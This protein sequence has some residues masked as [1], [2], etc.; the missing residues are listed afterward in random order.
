V[1]D[2]VR[3]RFAHAIRGHVDALCSVGGDRHPGSSRNRAAVVYAAQTM[4]SLGVE[5]EAIEFEVPE[6]SYGRAS[7]AVGG[8]I[9]EVHPGPF[10]P[11][12]AGD[13]RLV[14]ISSREALSGLDVA[15]AVVL[16]HGEIARSQFVPRDYPWYSDPRDTEFVDALEAAGPLAVIAA[17]G[18]SPETA[19][20]LS[21]FPLIDDVHFAIPSAC[22]GE[23]E[24][25]ALLEHEGERAS[26]LIDSGTTPSTGEQLIGRLPG[27]KP[28]R[29]VIAAHIDTKPDTPGALDNAAGV[30]T[31]LGVAELL[32]GAKLPCAVEL[33]PFNG[34]DHTASPGEV[35][36]LTAYPDL[37]DVRLM[38]NID[39]A[40]LAGGPTDCSAYGLDDR[41]TA[42]VSQ[43]MSG[44]DSVVEGPQWP[45]SD[46]M[47]FAMRGVPA[48]ALTAHDLATVMGAISHTPADTPE[49]VDPELLADAARFIAE[50]V[51]RL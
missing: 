29:I 31:L 20:A 35:A 39:D 30:A 37:S 12:L 36:Y 49:H 7:L 8:R 2:E 5:V 50:L 47:I 14:A 13:G 25:A 40:G 1:A 46:H 51:T 24:G 27:E 19:G 41:T 3:D 32:S 15:G 26:V 4:R 48:L 16:L 17:T 34:E 44:F 6:W 22:I 45:S 11:P 43:V 21:P 28:G 42:L 18:R 9:F 38:V 23:S 10:S 33:V